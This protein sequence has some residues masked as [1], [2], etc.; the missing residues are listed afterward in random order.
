MKTEGESANLLNKIWKFFVSV[1]LTVVLLLTLAVTSVI[2][3]LIPQNENPAA[4][5]QQYGP[6]LYKI[7]S[8]LNLFDMYHSW[9]FQLLLCLLTVN[10]V[11]CSVDRL[12]GTWRVIF[13]R[14]S[15]FS[16]G[17]FKKA[18]QETFPVEAPPDRLREVYLAPATRGFRSRK[19]EPAEGGGHRIFAEKGRWTRLGV[20]VVHFSVILLLLGGLAGS[21]LGFEGFVQIPEGGGE[22]TIRLKK[23]GEPH[24]LDFE[25]RCLDF[26][27]SFYETGAPKEFRSTLALVR[28]GETLTERDIIVNDPLRYGGISIYQS[29]YGNLPPRSAE[30]T[31]TSVESG[32]AYTKT[33]RVGEPV[34]MPEGAGTFMIREFVRSYTFM[35][36]MNLGDTFVARVAPVDGVPAEVI[37][38]LHHPDFDRMIV[39]RG[40]REGAFI[41]AVSGL[42]HH[43]YTGLQVTRD[44]GVWIVYSGFIVMILGIFITF[45][46]S[47]QRIL[48][49]IRPEGKGSR[50]TVAGIADKN[51]LGM[52]SRVKRLADRLRELGEAQKTS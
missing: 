34:E 47:H 25:I 22:R 15:P 50:V 26:D 10:I 23:T 38:P 24:T 16:P 42:D 36:R 37:L 46:M 1:R 11:A 33:A 9:W 20:Y 39:K 45:F 5:F 41:I 14:K 43:Y 35:G 51:R 31:F 27:V 18:P 32:M 4:Y 17:R 40:M 44:P 3:T 29:S 52:E 21:F 7:F 6:G 12:S 13:P 19:A 8:A 30:I 49:E 28:D 48:V 2:G